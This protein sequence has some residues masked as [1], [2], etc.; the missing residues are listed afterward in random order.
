V[1]STLFPYPLPLGPVPI[2]CVIPPLVP[3]DFEI[4]CPTDLEFTNSGSTSCMLPCPPDYTDLDSKRVQYLF[5]TIPSWI[6]FPFI[7][8][9]II[10]QLIFPVRHPSRCARTHKQCLFVARFSFCSGACVR[11]YVRACVRACMNSAYACMFGMCCLC[12]C[13]HVR[14]V[15]HTVL[16]GCIALSPHSTTTTTTT[17]CTA[18][19]THNEQENRTYP[20]RLYLHLSISILVLDLSLMIAV[21]RDWDTCNCDT[22]FYCTLQVVLSVLGGVWASAW[23]MITIFHIW[24]AVFW[25]THFGIVDVSPRQ[26]RITEAIYLLVGW[27]I[28]LV[29]IITL[30]ASDG[31]GPPIP[32]GQAAASPLCLMDTRTVW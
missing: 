14:A 28:A 31:W 3:E 8:L 27:G 32:A 1:N 29:P 23:W 20:R 19:R 22:G 15:V 2:P 16:L 5:M 12:A 24:T 10:T 17:L 9:L 13:V 18:A 11:A 21:F 25:R 30:S 7:I 6:S 4:D 26:N